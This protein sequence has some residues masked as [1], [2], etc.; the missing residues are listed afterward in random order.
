LK[1]ALEWHSISGIDV[2]VFLTSWASPHKLFG[3]SI[4]VWLEESTLPNFSMGSEC[5]VV[6][7]IWRGVTTL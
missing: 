1:V 6:P 7:S 3:V 5:S 2:P 4:H